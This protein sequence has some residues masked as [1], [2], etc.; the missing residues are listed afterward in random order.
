MNIEAAI[1]SQ[2]A[3]PTG[4]FGRLVGFVLA[5]RSSNVWRGR[6]TVDLLE[7]SARDLVLEVACGPGVALKACLER[8]KQGTAMGLDHS[9]VMIGQAR[10]RNAR[11]VEMKTLRLIVGTI[12]DL[13]A[14][15]RFDR[16]FSINLIQFLPDKPAFLVACMKRLAPNGMLATT[17]QPRG[18]KPTREA[19]F[20]MATTLTE[21]MTGLGFIDVR[22]EVLEMNPVPAVCVLGRKAGLT[23]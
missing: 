16:I 5:N 21:T 17:F 10:R 19:A 22:T 11:A 13:P 20:A 9:G 18:R 4:I 23:P 15:E 8:L 6:W 7:L 1:V 3:R 2:F 14:D 12:D